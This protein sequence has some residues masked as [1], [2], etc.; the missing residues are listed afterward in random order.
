MQNAVTWATLSP[1]KM[2]TSRIAV[3]I[4]KECLL[5]KFLC[6]SVDKNSQWSQV[7]CKSKC[8]LRCS[9]P[10][11]SCHLPLFGVAWSPKSGLVCSGDCTFS[12]SHTVWQTCLPKWP[13]VLVYGPG[14]SF[15]R[16]GYSN[17]RARSCRPLTQH[18]PATDGGTDEGI[19]A[20]VSWGASAWFPG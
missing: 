11:S 10:P 8:P 19:G 1:W 5:W 12:F 14:R 4:P 13:L 2:R 16:D 6:M 17:H 9:E 15:S 7:S 18:S 3:F 20:L